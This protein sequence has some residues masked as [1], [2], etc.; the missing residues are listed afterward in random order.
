MAGLSFSDL[1][2][3]NVFYTKITTR[4]SSS[5]ISSKASS[6]NNSS[7]KSK[8]KKGKEGYRVCVVFASADDVVT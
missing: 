5:K 2:D 3:A 4:E 8:K 1:E 7:S 6:S